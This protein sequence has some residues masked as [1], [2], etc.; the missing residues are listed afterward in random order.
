[1]RCTCFIDVLE[2]GESKSSVSKS[3]MP[4]F[5]TLKTKWIEETI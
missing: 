5:Y 2:V 4:Q 1:V 3:S